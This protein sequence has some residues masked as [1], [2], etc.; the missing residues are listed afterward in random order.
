MCEN[1]P[2]IEKQLLNEWKRFKYV[3][4]NNVDPNFKPNLVTKLFQAKAHSAAETKLLRTDSEV[5]QLENNY[6][7]DGQLEET[8]AC[9]GKR[10]NNNNVE[11]NNS[12]NAEYTESRKKIKT[13]R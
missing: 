13:P 2:D 1:L 5:E 7:A 11:M 9:Q 10:A 6:H 8:S 4:L 12:V 3:S